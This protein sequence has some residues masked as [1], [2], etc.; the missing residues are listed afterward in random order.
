MFVASLALP[1]E[2]DMRANLVTG[3]FWGA[4]GWKDP[5]TDLIMGNDGKVYMRDDRG[6]AIYEINEAGVQPI[7]K[8]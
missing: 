1:Q 7:G 2:L 4:Y 8:R 6:V 3:G 5:V